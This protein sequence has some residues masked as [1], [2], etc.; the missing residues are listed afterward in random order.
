MDFSIRIPAT[1][2]R[3][4][5]LEKYCTSKK[6]LPQIK[7]YLYKPIGVSLADFNPENVCVRIREFI[8]EAKPSTF[9][10]LTI[11][12]QEV[13]YSDEREEY[14]TGIPGELFEKAKEMN[15]EKW[16]E[17]STHTFEFQISTGNNHCSVLLQDLDQ[18][19]KYLKIEAPD[20]ETLVKTLALLKAN[21]SERIEKNA[22]VLLA[23]KMELI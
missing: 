11:V 19:G 6:E 15:F 22:G 16:G 21:E 2:E 17:F 9:I 23:E 13:G 18:I 8:D 10:K 5:F 20:Q 14:G 4:S 12:K 1:D 7:D 3:I